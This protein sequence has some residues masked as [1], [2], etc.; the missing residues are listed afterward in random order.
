MFFKF[1]TLFLVYFIIISPFQCFVYFRSNCTF[2]NKT[3]RCEIVKNMP[4]FSFRNFRF[5]VVVDVISIFTL[6]QRQS[7]SDWTGSDQL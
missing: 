4:F 7:F 6:K 3:L 5:S 2:V 1:L